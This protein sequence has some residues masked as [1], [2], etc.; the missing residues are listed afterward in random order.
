MCRRI[1]AFTD[2]ALAAGIWGI[3][4]TGDFVPQQA[5]EATRKLMSSPKRPTALIF[6]SEVMAIAGGTSSMLNQGAVVFAYLPLAPAL[7]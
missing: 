3:T 2:Y 4:L 5:K 6:D 1:D 7:R